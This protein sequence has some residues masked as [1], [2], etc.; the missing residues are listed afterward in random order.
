MRISDWSSDVCSSDLKSKRQRDETLR[1]ISHYMRSPH[2]SILALSSLQSQPDT[3][4]P[5]DLLL[6]RINQYAGKT[7]AL[8]DG[9]MLLARAESMRIH[10]RPI[11]LVDLIEQVRDDYWALSRQRHIAVTFEHDAAL[12][13]TGGDAD[14]KSTRMTSSH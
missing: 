6:Q 13:Y 7:L 5:E 2:N 10:S 12:A 1:F 9:F 11:D 3:R 4:L 14:R 8:V